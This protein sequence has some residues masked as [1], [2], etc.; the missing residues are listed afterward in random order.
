MPKETKVWLK[1]L[2][3]LLFF[4]W[5]YHLSFIKRST[6]TNNEKTEL[7]NKISGGNGNTLD[8]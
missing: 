5:E 8:G 7:E 4:K 6:T 2:G 1:Q 3:K